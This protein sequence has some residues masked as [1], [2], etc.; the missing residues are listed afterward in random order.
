[1]PF[2]VVAETTP[3]VN[4]QTQE[5]SQLVD[6]QQLAMLPSLTRNPYDFVALAGNVSGGDNATANA[7]GG[8]NQTAHGTGYSINGQRESG[9]KIL[10]DGIENENLFAAALGA[11]IPVDSVQEYSV[12]SN[13]FGSALLGGKFRSS[14]LPE[15]L[16]HSRAS[17]SS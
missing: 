5:I 9:S 15:V 12:I 3:D 14:Q 1:M 2:H 4:T 13:N 6:S 11:Q 7:N 8:R 17:L 10:L 16:P